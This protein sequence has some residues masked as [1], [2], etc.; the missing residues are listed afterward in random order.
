M[1]LSWLCYCAALGW[2]F[3]FNWNYISPG[4]LQ[5]L[6]IDD[7]ISLTGWGEGRLAKS[8]AEVNISLQKSVCWHNECS[9]CRKHPV[10]VFCAVDLH[11]QG[12]LRHWDCCRSTEQAQIFRA[13]CLLCSWS[14]NTWQNQKSSNGYSQTG[15]WIARNPRQ[16]VLISTSLW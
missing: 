9:I 15:C 6:W 8:Q 2:P 5:G 14:L 3:W 10:C 7:S 4:R 16:A 12:K 13:M 11:T 1:W